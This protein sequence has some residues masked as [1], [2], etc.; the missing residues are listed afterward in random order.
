MLETIPLIKQKKDINQAVHLNSC[1]ED[2][3][4]LQQK[5]QQQDEKDEK[6]FQE[7]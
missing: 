3:E 5:L 1:T 4:R 7:N 6:E 2:D